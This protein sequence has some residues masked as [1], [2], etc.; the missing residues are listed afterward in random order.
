MREKTRHQEDMEFTQDIQKRLPLG[1]TALVSSH[2]DIPMIKTDIS[3]AP[4]VERALATTN[5]KMTTSGAVLALDTIDHMLNTNTVVQVLGAPATTDRENTV[6]RVLAI[7]DQK[8]TADG[9]VL[10]ITDLRE[11]TVG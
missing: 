10:A 2:R 6:E 9:G 3:I 4:T 8:L 11:T 5:Q 1:T 7:I